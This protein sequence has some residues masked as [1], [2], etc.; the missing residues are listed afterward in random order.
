MRPFVA[1]DPDTAFAWFGRWTGDPDA[2]V[3]RLASEGA[4]RAFPGRT[5]L[6][7][8]IADPAPGDRRARPADRRPVRVRAPIGGQQPQRHHQG[9]PRPRASRWPG[10]GARTV[11]P[12]RSWIVRRGL[13]SL[14]VRRRPGG[15]RPAGLRRCRTGDPGAPGGD[16]VAGSSSGSRWRSASRCA[17]RRRR[18][19]WW[20]STWC[21]TRARAGPA[22]R[23]RSRSPAA[24]SRRGPPSPSGAGTPSRE[25]SIRR[26]YPGTHRVEIQ[27]NGRVLGGVDVELVEPER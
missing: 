5:R 15:A 6:T 13:R 3:R 25:R 11:T 18:R 2:H 21:T 1:H 7:A 24:P 14:A 10:A 20:C 4:A 23:G 9:P 22:R 16:A 8:L 27:V 12:A 19:R 26:L 17:P